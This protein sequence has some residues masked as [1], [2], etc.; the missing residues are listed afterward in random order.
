M[1]VIVMGMSKSGTTLVSKT[2]HE[3][4]INMSPGK[5][6]NYNQSKYEDPKIIKILLKMFNSDRLKSL[7]VPQNIIINQEIENEFKKYIESKTGDWGFKQPWITLCYEEIKRFLPKNHIAIG[8][9]RSFEGLLNHWH[10]R[11]KKVDVDHLRLVQNIYN[12]KMIEYGIPVLSFEK[13]LENGPVELEK[14]LNRK[15]KDVRA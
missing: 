5:T 1:I 6:G 12:I 11:G 4:G 13:F 2:L 15:L 3:S 9:K 14:I 8:I 10:K 7:Y